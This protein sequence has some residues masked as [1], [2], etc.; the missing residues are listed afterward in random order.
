M[1]PP[2]EGKFRQLG[3]SNYSSW[4][5]S[6]VANLCKAN[7]WVRPSVYQV[8]H[9]FLLLFPQTNSKRRSKTTVF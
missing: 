9:K 6:E 5:V 2:R 1:T 8:L 3:L 4:L 7:H